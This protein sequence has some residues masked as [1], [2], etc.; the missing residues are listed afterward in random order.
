MGK[1]NQQ[2]TH[3]SVNFSKCA[4]VVKK[5]NFFKANVAL[6]GK[7]SAYSRLKGD[8]FLFFHD[9]ILCLPYFHDYPCNTA[10]LS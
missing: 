1:Y 7:K 10:G 3:Q 4:F 6:W 2:D 9:Q 5:K 8:F